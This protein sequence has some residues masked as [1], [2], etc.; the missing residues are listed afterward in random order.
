MS[1]PL[2]YDTYSKKNECQVSKLAESDPFPHP[3]TDR[4]PAAATMASGS[5]CESF[6]VALFRVGF[7]AFGFLAFVSAFCPGRNPVG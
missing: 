4:F 1:T 7:L 6:S 3:T 5:P 2:E